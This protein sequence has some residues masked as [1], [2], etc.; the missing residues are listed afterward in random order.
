VLFDWAM[1]GYWATRRRAC[2]LVWPSLLEGKV[3]DMAA[4]LEAAVM[5]SYLAG[6]VETGWQGDPDMVRC[7]YLIHSVLIFGVV[8]EAV[9][10]ALHEDEHAA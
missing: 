10:Y 7:A 5:H 1:V 8:P 2:N 4:Q 9:A 3:V 6:L